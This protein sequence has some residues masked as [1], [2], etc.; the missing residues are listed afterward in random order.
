VIEYSGPD[1]YSHYAENRRKPKWNT[2]FQD[3]RYKEWRNK[4]INNQ[5][6]RC[7]KCGAKAT[8]AHHIKNYKHHPE[9]RYETTNGLLLC[10][11]HHDIF[12]R[13]YGVYNNTVNQ[14]RLFL[15]LS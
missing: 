9:L 14:I 7:A 4:V 6:G 13:V 1:E 5:N 11:Q 2:R 12:H 15:G 10:K 8:H 3:P